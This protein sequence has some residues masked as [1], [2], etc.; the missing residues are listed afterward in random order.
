MGRGKERLEGPGPCS[1]QASF[2]ASKKLHDYVVKLVGTAAWVQNPAPPP[3]GCVTV[4]KLLSPLCL[5]FLV[6][7]MG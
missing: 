2:P 4:D 1:T 5:T 7:K 6:C 3:A